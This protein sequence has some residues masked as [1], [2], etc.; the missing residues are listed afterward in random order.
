MTPRWTFWTAMVEVFTGEGGGEIEV[1]SRLEAVWEVNDEM[2]EVKLENTQ[3][4]EALLPV[5]GKSH[6][7]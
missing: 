7:C 1:N 6:G 4:F 5:V 3:R 2:Q